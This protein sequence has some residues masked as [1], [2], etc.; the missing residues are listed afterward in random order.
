MI[1][2]HQ[3]SLDMVQCLKTSL[4]WSNVN[5]M[6]KSGKFLFW[7]YYTV[8]KLYLCFS[9][10]PTF[11]KYWNI[12]PF[13]YGSTLW[14]SIVVL[15]L[16]TLADIRII[17]WLT[18]KL[19]TWFQWKDLENLELKDDQLEYGKYFI[20]KCTIFGY[21]FGGFNQGKRTHLF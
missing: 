12:V 15:S 7:V 17:N 2:P 19:C 14:L 1:Y 4:W 13:P 20:I 6:F 3:L 21:S 5:T 8:K 9:A 10:W 16:C 18:I 11:S